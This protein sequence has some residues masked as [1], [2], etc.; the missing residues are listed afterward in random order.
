LTANGT[1]RDG[2]DTSAGNSFTLLLEWLQTSSK[3][4]APRFALLAGHKDEWYAAI[5]RAIHRIDESRAVK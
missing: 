5:D 3:S 2:S 4:N 1:R